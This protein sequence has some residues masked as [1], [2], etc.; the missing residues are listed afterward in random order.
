LKVF[1]V[2]KPFSATKVRDF[3]FFDKTELAENRQFLKV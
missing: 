1:V 2:V 3:A